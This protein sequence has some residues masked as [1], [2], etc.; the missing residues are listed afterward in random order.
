MAEWCVRFVKGKFY[1]LDSG[2]TFS[3]KP[4][5]KNEVLKDYIDRYFLSMQQRIYS[6]ARGHAQKNLDVKQFKG[7]TIPLPPIEVQEQIVAELDGYQNIITG[8]KQII[9]NW[10]PKIEIDP[11][12]EKMPIGNIAKV[13]GGFAFKSQDMTEK[14]GVQIIKIGNVKD[15]RFDFKNNPSFI[16]I[17]LY[18]NYFDYQLSVGDI[19]ISMTGTAGKRDYGNVCMVDIEGKFLLNQRVG[20]IVPN[21]KVINNYLFFALHQNETKDKFYSNAT[22]G[23]RQGNISNKQ[24]ELIEIPLPPLEIQ[25]QLVAEM[26]EQEKIIEANKKLIGIMEQKIQDVLKKI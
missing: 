7:L 26:E 9:A 24:I 14:D 2:F 23:V 17:D 4:E 1:L 16:D 3:V 22:G 25:K 19:L 10:K 18:N 5:K 20:R 6:C 11:K 13:Q 8:A 21:S 12:W 15:Q